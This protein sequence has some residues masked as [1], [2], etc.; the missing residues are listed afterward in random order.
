MRVF[1]QKESCLSCL[2]PP[3]SY[4]GRREQGRQ[5]SIWWKTLILILGSYDCKVKKLQARFGS[6]PHFTAADLVRSVNKQIRQSYL[7]K[8]LL[9]SYKVGIKS[10]SK[11]VFENHLDRESKSKSLF[12]VQ[13][14]L[15]SNQRFARYKTLSLISMGRLCNITVLL[16]YDSIFCIPSSSL[17]CFYKV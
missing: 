12:G 7:K 17:S 8:R 4:E 14:F 13:I 2:H 9:N 3:S 16:A 11:S 1:H 6:T 15:D 5:L 10:L